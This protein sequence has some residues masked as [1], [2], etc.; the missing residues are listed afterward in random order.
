MRFNDILMLASQQGSG[1]PAGGGGI[2]ATAV[3]S[4]DQAS[5][6][7]AVDAAK[8]YAVASWASGPLTVD[9]GGTGVTQVHNY[10]N[11][12]TFYYVPSSSGTKTFAT[13]SRIISI[14]EV[15][16][17]STGYNSTETSIDFDN[18]ADG[19][20][21]APGSVTDFVVMFIVSTNAHTVSNMTSAGSAYPFY[22]YKETGTLTPAGTWGGATS[23]GALGFT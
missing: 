9:G 1:A 6:D 18:R 21:T 10:T 2:T 19:S 13:L 17:F 20:F 23:L 3:F 11:L 7:I 14:V 8:I 4:G 12:K 15:A 5:V 16:G 22:S